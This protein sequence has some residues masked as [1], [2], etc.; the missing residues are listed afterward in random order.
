MTIRHLRIFLAV[1]DSG[2]MTEAAERLFMSQPSVSQ[3][4]REMEEHYGV[5]LFDRISKKLFLTDQGQRVLQY[6]RH[7]VSLMDEMEAAVGDWD[8]QGILKVGTSITIGTYL[9]PKYAKAMKERFPQLQVEALIGNSERIE[10]CVLDNEIDFGVIEG[11]AHSPYIVSESFPGDSLVFI[12]P[13]EHGFNKRGDVELSQLQKEEF[14]LREKGSAGREIFDGLAAAH[15]LDIRILW[16]SASNQA[17]I[18][19]VEAGF[20]LSLLPQ[21]LVED[22]IRNGELGTFKVRGLSME[23]KFA[24]IYHKNKFLSPGAKAM[25]GMFTA[26]SI[27]SA[28]PN[29]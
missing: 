23:R 7:I 2:S 3:A 28:L 20:G 17:I 10:R 18:H 13:K 29:P 5:R 15:E 1:C 14:I 16:Q 24:V 26:E 11:V 8:G 4:V 22:G 12:C 21:S 6:G 25:A 9:L 19:G 27:F